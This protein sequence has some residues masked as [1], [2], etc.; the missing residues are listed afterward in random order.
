MIKRR[1]KKKAKKERL[2]DRTEKYILKKHSIFSEKRVY[3]NSRYTFLENSEDLLWRSTNY[4]EKSGGKLNKTS[5]LLT[6]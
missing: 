4:R 2:N 5:S 6:S 3:Y 1:Q